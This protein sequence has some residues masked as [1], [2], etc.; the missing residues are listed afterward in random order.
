MRLVSWTTFL[1]VLSLCA[2]TS[3]ASELPFYASVGLSWTQT[4][5]LANTDVPNITIFS[6]GPPDVLSRF[7]EELPLNGQAFDDDDSG[8]AVAL[9]YRITDYLG[10]ELGYEDLGSFQGV[11]SIIGAAAIL[12]SP[13]TI[14]AS[15]LSLAARFNY[16]LSERIYATWRLALIRAEF[17]AGG[18]TFVA[19]FPQPIPEPP[20][21]FFDIP[22][23]D[24]ANETGYGFGF[25]VGWAFNRHFEAEL[26]YSRQDL[27]VLEFD[28]IGLRF[29]A[30]L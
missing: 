6:A 5:G 18:S 19:V 27:R 23:S 4:D 22:F 21:S 30:R 20:L 26:A 28:S 25:G 16:Y 24:P 10:V 14:D 29:I 1:A 3:G 8:W 15:G 12:P 13:A 7:P 2:G 9:G 17:E 11:A